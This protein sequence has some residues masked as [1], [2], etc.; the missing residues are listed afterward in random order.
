VNA[1]VLHQEIQTQLQATAPL[2]NLPGPA[3]TVLDP[4]DAQI[5]ALLNSNRISDS[6]SIRIIQG[7]VTAPVDG[8][9]SAEL[10]QRLAGFQQL[11]SIP[12]NG[13]IEDKLTLP[14]MVARLKSNRSSTASGRS[15]SRRSTTTATRPSATTTSSSRRITASPPSS[16]CPTGTGCPAPATTSSSC[17]TRPTSRWPLTCRGCSKACTPRRACRY[18]GDRDRLLQPTRLRRVLHPALRAQDG[19]ALSPARPR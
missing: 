6:R 8:V 13:L 10:V 3:P 9:W 5:A 12:A 7:L 17:I 11:N 16:I 4:M 14:A 15:R 18:R 19:A 2:P 1:A